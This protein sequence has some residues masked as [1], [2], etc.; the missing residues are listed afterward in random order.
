MK[1]KLVK[2]T[3][4][5]KELSLIFSL[6]YFFFGPLY[7]LFY[8]MVWKFLFLTIIY[9]FGIWKNAGELLI[10][11]LISWGIEE[12]YVSFLEI[13]G[14]YYF[15]TLGAVIGLHIILSFVTSR[16]I[17]KRLVHKKGYIPYSEIDAQL[18]VKYSIAK[19]GTMSYLSNDKAIK[20]VQGKIKIE[21]PEDLNKKLEELAELLKS[22]MITKDEYNTKRAQALMNVASKK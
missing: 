17:I 4:E 14:K 10:K 6:G 12:K 13:P 9:V 22:G 2:R 8:K 19:V 16:V 15:I 3:G 18:L 7:Y 5:A 11:L 1:A 21:N 20:G